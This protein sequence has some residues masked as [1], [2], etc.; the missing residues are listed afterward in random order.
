MRTTRARKSNRGKTGR[1]AQATETRV[2][3]QLEEGKRYKITASLEKENSKK[4]GDI[5]GGW[6]GHHRTTKRGKS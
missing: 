5:Y 6:F 1:G 3:T 4:Q 2:K